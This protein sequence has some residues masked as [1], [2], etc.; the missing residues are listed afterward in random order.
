[1][2]PAFLIADYDMPRSSGTRLGILMRRLC[3][4]SSILI[5][6]AYCPT[7]LADVIGI[8]HGEFIPSVT[9]LE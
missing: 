2:R 8:Q 6:S 1:V 3:P 7:Q 4:A 5:I 9:S